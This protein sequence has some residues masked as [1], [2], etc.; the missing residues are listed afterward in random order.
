MSDDVTNATQQLYWNE[1]GGPH[2]VEQQTQFDLMLAEFG[3]RALAV[4]DARPGER[5]LDVGC[6][7]GPTTVEIAAAVG[8]DGTVVGCDIATTMVDAARTRGDGLPQLSFV[9]ADAQTDDLTGGRPF[10]AVFSR[11]GVMFFADPTAAFAN[12]GRQVRPGGRLTFACWQSEERNDW[13]SVPVE[14]MRRFT[15]EPVLP[16]PG[17]PGPFAFGE[18]SVIEAV[19][20][21]SGWT[22]ISIDSF[23]AATVLGAGLGVEPA[24]RQTMG[25][26]AGQQLRQ[27]VDDATFAAAADAIRAAFAEHLVDGRVVYDGNVWI[28]R[29]SRP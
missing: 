8:P 9:V 2:W 11:F 7:T 27:Q 17:E 6:G 23:T 3:A 29:A 13:L 19:L 5:I 14:I 24:V 10:D 20:T 16:P 28:V 12:L 1:V 26:R 4:L 22:D 18:S 25:N 21:G 15:P